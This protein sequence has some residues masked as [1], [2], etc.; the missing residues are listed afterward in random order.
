[1]S[2]SKVTVSRPIDVKHD[3]HVDKYLNWTFDRSVDPQTIFTQIKELGKG[4]FGVVYEILHEPSGKHLAGKVINSKLIDSN[5]IESIQKEVE[6]LRQINDDCAVRYYG[7]VTHGPSIMIL[8]ELCDKGSLRDIL[9]LREEA[10]S[11]VQIALV[12]K[13]LLLALNTLHTKHRIIHRD[14][15]AANI[16]LTS[17]SEIKVAD[18][19]VSRRFDND[20][21][22]Q[23]ATIIGTPYWMAPE[24]INGSGYS[25]PADIWSVGMTAVELS[26]GAPPYIELPP[27]KAMMEIANNGFPGFRFPEMHSDQFVDFVSKCVEMN[28]NERSTITQ[29]LEHPFIKRSGMLPRQFILMDLINPPPRSSSQSTQEFTAN[30]LSNLSDQFQID[31]SLLPLGAKIQGFSVRNVLNSVNGAFMPKTDVFGNLII[32]TKYPKELSSFALKTAVPL[33]SQIVP[34][35]TVS[36][37]SSPIAQDVE[38]SSEAKQAFEFI[39][40][41]QAASMKIP[42]VKCKKGTTFDPSKPKTIY[43]LPNKKVAKPSL[44][45]KNTL[46]PIVIVLSVV[47]LLLFLKFGFVGLSLGLIV[48]L[49]MTYFMNQDKSK[50]E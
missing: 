34:P 38:L 28:P 7:C 27:T 23:T 39:K 5:T 13:D 50:Q 32:P 17:E 6:L 48:A 42:F 24:V 21:V 4:G 49:A 31:E 36:S 46:P 2:K 37:E 35:T 11:E 3:I 15:K 25:F 20:N 41:S 19:G 1:M 29:L 30:E 16:L 26:E 22:C 40:I 43:T 18:F 8:M 33:D 47:L 10:F 14:I 12:M 9:D 44:A 45:K